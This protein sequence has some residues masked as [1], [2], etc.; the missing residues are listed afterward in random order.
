M[1]MRIIMNAANLKIEYNGKILHAVLPDHLTLEQKKTV[2]KMAAESLLR[3]EI[4]ALLRNEDLEVA[5]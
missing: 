5:R 2:F 3:D 1:N 4:A